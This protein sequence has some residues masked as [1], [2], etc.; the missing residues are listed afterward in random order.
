[1]LISRNAWLEAKPGAPIRAE[2]K[3]RRVWVIGAGVD[4]SEWDNFKNERIVAINYPGTEDLQT[5]SSKE[6]LQQRVWVDVKATNDVL[7]CWQF[8]NEMRADDYVFV[9]HGRRTLPGLGKVTGGYEFDANRQDF[10]HRR[11]VEKEVDLLWLKVLWW[12][13]KM[14]AVSPRGQGGIG[15]FKWCYGSCIHRQ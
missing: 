10:K 2:Q 15:I 6:N 4:G 14:V 3:G 7:G 12:C 8:A 5:Y 13:N 1:M 11:S 9:K